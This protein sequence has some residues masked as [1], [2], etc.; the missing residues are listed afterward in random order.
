MRRV[1]GTQRG[2]YLLLSSR[3]V[4]RG[5]GAGRQVRRKPEENGAEEAKGDEFQGKS[6]Q[7]VKVAEVK[8]EEYGRVSTEQFKSPLHG[9]EQI[10][11]NCGLEA[12]L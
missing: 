12:R 10:Q 8:Q 2:D 7:A 11:R 3:Q 6:H 1:L 5:E 4:G 9:D